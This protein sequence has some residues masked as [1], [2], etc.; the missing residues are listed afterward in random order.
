MKKLN[1]PARIFAVISVL[2]GAVWLGSYI[3]RLVI[4]YQ[5]FEENSTAIKSTIASENL[6][7][8]IHAISP[9]VVLTFSVYIVFI[10]MFTFFLLSSD[11]KLKKSGWLMIIA[12][13]VYLT[14]PF[15]IYLMFIDW[16]LIAATYFNQ[17][18]TSK[19]IKLVVERFEN[20]RGFPIILII[21]YLTLPYFLIQQPFTKNE[22]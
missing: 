5:I 15:E 11:I 9:S 8:I 16:K 6:N 2:A 13:I 12:L 20:L 14:M 22:N 19:L 18:G 3:T 4:T 1:V 10:I 21:S 7:F 17:S